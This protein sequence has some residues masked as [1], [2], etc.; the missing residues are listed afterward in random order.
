VADGET[1][2]LVAPSNSD[3]L[4]VSLLQYVRN[5]DLARA[6]GRA[7]RVRVEAGFSLDGMVG[8]YARLYQTLSKS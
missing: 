5:P 2:I 8:T 7:G 6:H 1:G 3:E 4:A